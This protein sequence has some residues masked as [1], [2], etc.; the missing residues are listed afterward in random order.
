MTLLFRL[1]LAGDR[2][3]LVL[4]LTIAFLCGLLVGAACFTL[5]AMSVSTAPVARVVRV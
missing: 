4:M 1:A 3:S 2:S 5:G